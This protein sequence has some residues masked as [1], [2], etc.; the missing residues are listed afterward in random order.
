MSLRVGP[1]AREDV[2]EIVEYMDCRTPGR[3]EEFIAAIGKAYAAIEAMPLIQPQSNLRPTTGLQALK[4]A[5][6]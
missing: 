3:G 1:G 4:L 6:T 5:T 2:A